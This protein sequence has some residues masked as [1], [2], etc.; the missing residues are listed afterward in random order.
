VPK[1]KQA[2]DLGALYHNFYLNGWNNEYAN[3]FIRGLPQRIE[4]REYSQR[5]ID[6]WD[7]ISPEIVA[8]RHFGSRAGIM[9][10]TKQYRDVLETH[11]AQ[12]LAAA[13]GI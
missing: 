9:E 8:R 1:T 7:E 3:L 10:F 5:I 13:Q 4:F 12:E 2:A 11:K 6:V